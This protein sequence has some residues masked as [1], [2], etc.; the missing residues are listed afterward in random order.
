VSIS[1]DKWMIT[2][3]LPI[4]LN[5][6]DNELIDDFI[7]KLRDEGGFVTVIHLLYCFLLVIYLSAILISFCTYAVWLV[8]MDID[9]YNSHVVILLSNYYHHHQSF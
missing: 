5:G 9:S 3:W 7:A 8:R 2:A 1:L 4:A 6:F